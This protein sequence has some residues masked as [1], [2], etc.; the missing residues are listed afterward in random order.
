MFL[1]FLGW[2]YNSLLVDRVLRILS[3]VVLTVMEGIRCLVEEVRHNREWV[4]M[5]AEMANYD[6]FRIFGRNARLCQVTFYIN[7]PP[8]RMMSYNLMG[9]PLCSSSY[10]QAT[11]QPYRQALGQFSSSHGQWPTGLN[12]MRF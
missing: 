4:S 3:L 11:R 12:P 8:Q 6:S 5:S 2:R 1:W 10:G 9:E 7:L